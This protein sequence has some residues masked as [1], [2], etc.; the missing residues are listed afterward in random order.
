MSHD[1]IDRILDGD[2]VSAE[3]L[4]HECARCCAPCSC[5][6]EGLEAPCHLCEACNRDLATD[7]G[8]E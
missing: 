8:Y 4:E 3:P 6:L 7:E 1:V 2:D 5:G